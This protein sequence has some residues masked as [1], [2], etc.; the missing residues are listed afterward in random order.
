MSTYGYDAVRRSTDPQSHSQQFRSAARRSVPASYAYQSQNPSAPFSVHSRGVP[1]HDMNR[2]RDVNLIVWS[3][4]RQLR[5]IGS[6]FFYL[7]MLQTTTTLFSVML[8]ILAYLYFSFAGNVARGVTQGSAWTLAGFVVFLPMLGLVGFAFARRERALSCVAAVKSKTLWIYLAHRDWV[9]MEC[10]PDGHLVAVQQTL[11]NILGEMRGYL[12]PPRYY[13]TTFPFT[14]VRSKMMNIAQERTRYI[15]RI[16]SNFKKLSQYNEPLRRAGLDCAGIAKLTE[17]YSALHLA[18]EEMTNIKE[19]RTPLPIRA[20]ARFYAAVVFPVF[21]GPYYVTMTTSDGCNVCFAILMN[22]ASLAL[23]NT[24]ISMEDPF[25]NQG[26]DGVYIDEPLSECEQTVYMDEDNELELAVHESMGGALGTGLMQP[27]QEED[28]RAIEAQEAFSKEEAAS[29][30]SKLSHEAVNV[31]VED[32]ATPPSSAAV[33]RPSAGA[34]SHKESEHEHP[35]EMS[36][37]GSELGLQQSF[38]MPPASPDD[39]PNYDSIPTSG[40]A[41]PGSTVVTMDEEQGFYKEHGYDGMDGTT[42]GANPIVFYKPP[43]P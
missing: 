29:K 5:D 4:F 24:A 3:T 8:T 15:R 20:L 11:F 23:L 30:E 17:M 34:A 13:S 37:A 31:Y 33:H 19:F 25:D 12:L 1:I 10:L 35:H 27:L 6:S 40:G 28:Q 21:F 7:C 9:P 36:G 16:A 43:Q 2:F 39:A 38:V 26:L 18:F 22:F 32:Q 41:G 14:G 42:D